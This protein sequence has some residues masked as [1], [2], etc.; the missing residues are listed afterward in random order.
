MRW[1]MSILLRGL[2]RATKRWCLQLW[3]LPKAE[4]GE[5]LRVIWVVLVVL[6]GVSGAFQGMVP[7]ERN[8]YRPYRVFSILRR[9]CSKASYEYGCG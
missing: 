1:F 8:D 3:S 4:E 7:M 5:R 9:C 6:V 2:K